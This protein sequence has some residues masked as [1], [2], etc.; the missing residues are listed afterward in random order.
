MF[1]RIKHTSIYEYASLVCDS[2]NEV[3]MIPR[4]GP[5]QR[6]WKHSLSITPD[7]EVYSFKD[8]YLN[9]VYVVEVSEKHQRLEVVSD[10]LVESLPDDREL[11]DRYFPRDRLREDLVDENIY[12]FLADSTYVFKDPDIWKLS[13]DALDGE[14]DCIWKAALRFCDFIHQHFEYKPESTHVESRLADILQLKKGVCQDFAHVMLGM[15]RVQEIPARYVSGYF[16]NPEREHEA[17]AS[18]AW[19]EVYI[20]GEGWVGLDPTHKRRVDETYV[21][22]AVGRDYRDVPP[23]SGTYRGTSNRT[24]IVD[25]RV[26]RPQLSELPAGV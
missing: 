3:R 22:V 12:D 10:S 4:S 7:A 1:I 25:V 6:R 26:T 18:H 2:V 21:K 15:C 24:L 20:P 19:V 14:V 13:V 17:Q 8:F 5:L 9:G 11:D 16:Y 23:V